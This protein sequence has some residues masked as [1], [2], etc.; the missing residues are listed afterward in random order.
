MM[1][2]YAAF[3]RGINVGGHTVTNDRLR[4]LF[5]ELGLQ[6]VRTFLASGNLIFQSE[7]VG[8][9][10]LEGRIESRLRDGLGYEVPTFVRT[11]EQVTAVAG[12][13]PFPDAPADG[14]LHIAFLRAELDAA[15]RHEVA[16]LAK[17]TD[18]VAF[19]DRELYWLVAGRFMDSA[20]SELAVGRVLGA[21]WTVRTAKTV[22]RVAA[23]LLR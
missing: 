23:K 2:S 19:R 12:H 15:T 16:A 13:T 14:K 9:S 8:V 5:E 20:L 3:L 21:D 11:V 22:Q 18:R 4:E 1:A 10:A 6:D 7:D 17:D